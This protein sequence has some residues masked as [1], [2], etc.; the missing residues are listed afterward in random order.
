MGEN[1]MSI[2]PVVTVDYDAIDKGAQAMYE[3][4]LLAFFNELKLK[5]LAWKAR[6]NG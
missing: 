6:I 5:A 2:R 1:T 3:L 4:D